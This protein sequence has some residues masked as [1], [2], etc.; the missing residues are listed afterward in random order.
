VIE[1][2]G[3]QLAGN[4]DTEYKRALLSLLSEKFDPAPLQRGC[5]GWTMRRPTS[6][7][8]GCCAGNWMRNCQPS[9]GVAINFGTKGRQM[10]TDSIE[11][12][13]VLQDPRK[14]TVPIYQRKYA[15]KEDRLQT[16]WDDLVSKANELLEGPPKFQH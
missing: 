16:L 8:Q 7:R 4:P 11:V 2:K 6:V 12:G 10:K 9:F 14:L 3:E 5:L 13:R 1:T 15:W